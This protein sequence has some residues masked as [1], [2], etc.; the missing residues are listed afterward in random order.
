MKN[1]LLVSLAAVGTGLLIVVLKFG[2]I[3]PCGIV[4]AE[5]RQQAVREGQFAQV[6]AAVIPDSVIDAMIASQYGQLTP[7]R[8]I[9]LAFA[10]VP[11]HAPAPPPV[12]PR[13][14]AP[15]K[16]PASQ[17][18]GFTTPQSA[19]AAL[20][21]A[22]DESKAAIVECKNNRRSGVLKTYMES[23]ECSNPRIIDAYQKSGY[24]YMDLIYLLTA[25]R[26]AL[27]EKIDRGTLT[28]AEAE[29]EAAQFTVQLQDKE[30]QRDGGQR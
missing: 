4:R 2:T 19:A 23:V 10:G 1:A 30:R 16:P 15:M 25:K 11:P 7:G 6:L 17:P 3:D 24:R 29:L 14:S 13:V 9:S 20:T 8:C 21:Q 26:R 28:E 5:V 12:Q 18:G 27:A 22:R